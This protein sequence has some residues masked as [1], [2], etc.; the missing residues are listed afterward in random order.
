M[1]EDDGPLKAIR[2]Q[3]YQR[4]FIE[5]NFGQKFMRRNS[6]LVCVKASQNELLNVLEALKI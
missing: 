4:E 6:N 3:G 2:G 1:F 5:V